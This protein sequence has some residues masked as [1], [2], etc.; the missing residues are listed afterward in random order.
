MRD[1]LFLS[2]RIPYPPDKGD[3]IRS[4]HMFQHL[5]R[6]FRMHLGCLV[7]DPDDVAR[8]EELRPLCAD[9]ACIQIDPRLQRLKALLRARPGQPLTLGY[10]HD[11]RLQRWVNAT[12][13][14][15]AIRHVFVY[16]SAVAHYV[17]RAPR[18]AADRAAGWDPTVGPGVGPGAG[19]GTGPGAGNVRVLD[20]VDVDSTKWSAYAATARWPARAVFAREGRT[21]LAFE[22]RAA[23][24]FSRSIFVNEAEWRHF[25]ELAPEARA[26][27][28]WVE[29]GVDLAHFSPTLAFADPFPPMEAT[30]GTGTAQTIA[31]PT[32]PPIGPPMAPSTGTST[33]ASTGASTDTHPGSPV[34]APSSA[35]TGDPGAPKL[36]F[37]GHMGYRPNID[38]VSW[39]ARAVMPALR[40]R[41]PGARFAIVGASPSPEVRRLAELPGVIVTGRVADTRPWLAHASIVVA[42][43]LIGRGTQNKVLEGMAMA[44][45]VIATP[46]AFEGV[47]AVP[48]QDIL[49]ASGVEQTIERIIDVLS[50]RHPNLGAAA[51]RAVELR[52]DWSVTLARLDDLFPEDPVPDRP[53]ARPASPPVPHP[54]EVAR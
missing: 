6:R 21:L 12:L 48:G 32:G 47:Q 4:W 35:P 2:H 18:S 27:T 20:M 53:A 46:E 14:R 45:P 19:S 26:Y 7:D 44:R 54:P 15:Y 1:L 25:V 9:L 16:S 17:M 33:G 40:E 42:P 41:L 11:A 23:R 51:R 39:F 3:K 52:H 30:N 10:F 50:G 38:A 36:V 28:G 5:A 8:I 37:T 31:P 22:R 49:L 34:G 43:L 29:N 24:A 13:E